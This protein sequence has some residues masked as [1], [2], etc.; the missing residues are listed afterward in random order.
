MK[1]S[2]SFQPL[3]DHLHVNLNPIHGNWYE[4]RMWKIIPVVLLIN[5][6]SNIHS[7]TNHCFLIANQLRWIVWLYLINSFWT[8]NFAHTFFWVCLYGGKIIILKLNYNIISFSATLFHFQS[9]FPRI[10]SFCC[11]HTGLILA[12]IEV[13]SREYKRE[14]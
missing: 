4:F 10:F 9:D 14:R 13:D 6:K 5:C 12:W 11:A 8:L 1:L 3:F 7:G 2:L